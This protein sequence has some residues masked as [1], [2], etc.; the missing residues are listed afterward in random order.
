M[1]ITSS[2]IGAYYNTVQSILTG[3]FGYSQFIAPLSLLIAIVA[4][5]IILSII[6]MAFSYIFGWI[7]RKVMARVQ[8]RH[9][10]TY[11]GKWGILQN[12]ADF[13]KLVAKENI[14][15]SGA[16]RPLL[17]ISIPI[18]V[19]IFIFILAFIP[20]TQ[21]FVGLNTTVSLILVFMLLSLTPLL[22]F[23]V[24]WA[25]GNKFGSIAAQRSVVM[26]LSYEVPIVLVVAAVALAA[27]G[28]SFF[29]IVNAQSNLWF[30]ALMPIGF[31][32]FFVALLGELERPPFDLREADS[33]LIAGWL[34]DVSAPYYGL[35]LLLDYTRMFVGSLL[36][37]ILFFGGWLGPSFIPQFGWLL[38]KAVI[39]ALVV[40]II[41]A[42]TVR[43]RMDRL[44][45]LGWDYLMPLSVV[46]LLITFAVLF[47]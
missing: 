40:I 20:L 23:V 36:V 5:L 44:L 29:D 25:S 43:M 17:Q 8:S 45:K 19:A 10:P 2:D 41:R 32:V 30:V 46:N 42:T 14:L 7:E 24:G 38:I 37:A 21:G 16:D 18:V 13:I 15:P 11:V 26:M 31:V 34:T 3:M 33:E 27:N 22:L 12:L 39:I 1:G 28:Y 4:F 9:G 6:F 47:I 35:V